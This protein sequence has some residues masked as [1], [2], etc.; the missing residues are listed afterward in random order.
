M[1]GLTTLEVYNSIFKIT[2]ENN[3]FELYTDTLDEFFFQ[4]LKGEL[5]EIV[6]ISN[7][8]HEQLQDEIVGPCIIPA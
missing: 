6:N 4:V 8:S 2:E 3:K 7:I 5:E 1:V